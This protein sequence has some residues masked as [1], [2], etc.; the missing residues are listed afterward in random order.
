M[1]LAE[2]KSIMRAFCTF[3]KYSPE[4]TLPQL[5]Y[6]IRPVVVCLVAMC[7]DVLT[8]SN[9]FVDQ[10]QAERRHGRRSIEIKR[11]KLLDLISTIGIGKVAA[12]V[13]KS[14]INICRS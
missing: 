10:S 5:I 4:N 13:V 8:K 12:T 14:T 7:A 3:T 1:D 2:C 9:S 11:S 6:E